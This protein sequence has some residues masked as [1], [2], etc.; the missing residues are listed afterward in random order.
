MKYI[1]ALGIFI[2]VFSFFSLG[3]TISTSSSFNTC[4]GLSSKS[5][6]I[7]EIKHQQ[8]NNKKA[9]REV[10]FWLFVTIF[11][12]AGI[13][14]VGAISSFAFLFGTFL[15]PLFCSDYPK[16]HLVTLFVMG[17]ISSIFTSIL[18]VLLLVRTEAYSSIPFW[19]SVIAFWFFVILSIINFRIVV[20]RKSA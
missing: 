9:I 15:L 8:N 11:T 12:I 3:G 6:S 16:T 20:S 19:L 17:I 7:L 1:F 13:F 18:A 5:K 4:S 2:V 10:V 14:S